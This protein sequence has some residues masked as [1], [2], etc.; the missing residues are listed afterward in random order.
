MDALNNSLARTIYYYSPLLERYARI[1]IRDQAVADRLVQEVLEDQY[2][3]DRLAP[4]KEL[5]NILKTDVRNRCHYYLQSK[6]F[7]R[8][9]I[10]TPV[11]KYPQPPTD[12]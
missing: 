8:G 5:R 3:I 4:S 9:V 2:E 10:K 12:K 11:R 6:I 7:N 1:Q